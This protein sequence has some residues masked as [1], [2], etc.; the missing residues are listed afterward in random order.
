M[1][2]LIEKMDELIKKITE[3][4]EVSKNNVGTDEKPSTIFYT[5]KDVAKSLQCSIPTAR[6]VM[7]RNDF[8]L[9]KIGKGERVL[10]E[11]L[12]QWAMERRE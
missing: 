6:A 4:L 7:H 5:V 10:K 11:A 1:N 2:E 3:L 12:E 8:K 9:I